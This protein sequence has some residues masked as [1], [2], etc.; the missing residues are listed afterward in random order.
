LVSS[1]HLSVTPFMRIELMEQVR[2]AAPY[3]IGVPTRAKVYPLSRTPR[4]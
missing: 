1:G 2:V 3:Q 4:W